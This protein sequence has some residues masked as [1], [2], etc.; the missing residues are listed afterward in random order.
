MRYAVPESPAAAAEWQNALSS[1]VVV[2][3][4]TNTD[5]AVSR[6]GA[7]HY[8]AHVSNTDETGLTTALQQLAAL[9]QTYLADTQTPSDTAASH[10]TEAT[11]QD[12]A[13]GIPTAGLVGSACIAYGVNCLGIIRIPAPMRLCSIMCSS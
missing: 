6:F 13:N 5:I 12:D 11:S 3:K 7:N 1:N 2:Y 9:L 4:V 10:Q 8:T